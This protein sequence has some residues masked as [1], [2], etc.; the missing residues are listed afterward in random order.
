[1]ACSAGLR[2]VDWISP[3]KR[4]NMAAAEPGPPARNDLPTKTRVNRSEPAHIELLI[5]VYNE[6]A[7]IETHLRQ[8]IDLAAGVEPRHRLSVLL[9]DDGSRDGTVEVLERFCRAEPRARYLAFTRNFG[10]EAA[11]Q[12]GLE[13]SR[14]DA[15]V[16]LDSDLQHPP[17]LIPRMVE[18]W[19]N[20][21]KVVEA[22]KVQR[23]RESAL[24]RLLATTF[25]RLFHALSGL[26]LRN[27]CDFKLLD[28]S[29]VD[30]YRRLHEQARFFRG[31]VQWM[32]FPTARLPF[33]VPERSGGSS[34]WSRVKLLRYALH[35][36]TSFSA[37]PLQLVS[38][39]GAACLIVG[40]VFAAISLVQK[41][42]GR[43]LDGF[44]TV[45]LLQIFFSGA[46]MLSLGIIGHYLARVYEEIK[47]RPAYLLA[48][49][50][51]DP[52]RPS[53][54]DARR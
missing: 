13:H 4:F 39:C 46:L 38:W 32:N 33:S 21:I 37:L 44:T 22:H 34:G 49:P 53:D 6:A 18:L 51:D 15:V 2:R 20:G 19:E 27:Q 41:W 40:S 50:A 43:A 48:P 47:H 42:Q 5:P 31:L 35:N 14:A 25:Y 10:K 9:V 11:I 52:A 36:I 7:V 23:G 54:E 3:A 17:E 8:I 16:I 30:A 29:V 12:A 24:S 28:R 45:I 1:M 26:D